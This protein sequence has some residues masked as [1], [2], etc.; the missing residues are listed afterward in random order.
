MV[1]WRISPIRQDNVCDF[2]L[3]CKPHTNTEKG[4]LIFWINLL[5]LSFS[6]IDDHVV[7]PTMDIAP[8]KP[9][10]GT[11]IRLYALNMSA[12]KS[13]ASWMSSCCASSWAPSSSDPD[14]SKYL[15]S[16]RLGHGWTLSSPSTVLWLEFSFKSFSSK[17]SLVLVVIEIV[18]QGYLEVWDV[19]VL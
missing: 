8:S 6:M 17:A 3:P 2:P 7:C 1:Q 13:A 9:C 15:W 4:I 5:S 14:C 11:C 12:G 16:S 18:G 19:K 10:C